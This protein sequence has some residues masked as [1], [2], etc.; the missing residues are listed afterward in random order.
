[1][2]VSAARIAVEIFEDERPPMLSKTAFRADIPREWAAEDVHNHEI[3]ETH[4]NAHLNRGI[5]R[6]RGNNISAHSA[7]SAV[8][9]ELESV[10][11]CLI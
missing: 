7:Y 10:V 1:M 8:F 11:S 2:P 6:I 5:R 3:D 9:A 4:E